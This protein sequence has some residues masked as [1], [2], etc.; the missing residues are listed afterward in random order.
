MISPQHAKIIVDS[1]RYFANNNTPLTRPCV[2]ELIR[3]YVGMLGYKERMQFDLEDHGPSDSC[4][5]KLMERNGL[6]HMSVQVVEDK[7]LSA[8]TP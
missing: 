1:L 3:T 8:I 4:I 2:R 7:L 5:N 6:K